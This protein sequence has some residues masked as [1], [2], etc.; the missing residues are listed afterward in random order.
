[1]HNLMRRLCHNK[2]L[3][4]RLFTQNIDG[5]DFQTGTPLESIVPV[6]GTMGTVSCEA[7]KTA[8]PYDDF[9]KQV[10][11]NI[12]DIYKQVRVQ[13]LRYWASG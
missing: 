2:G 11:C 9:R 12:K 7:C 10:Q 5:L 1:M 4:T 6:H 13:I 8:Y 3:L